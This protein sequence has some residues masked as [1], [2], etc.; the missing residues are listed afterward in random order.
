MLYNYKGTH[1]TKC[2]CQCDCGTKDVIRTAYQ[3]KHA[4]DSSCGCGRK[5]YI[6]KICGKE[7]DG[8]KFGR[9]TVIETMWNETPVRVKCSCE[10]GNI[11]IYLK[12]DVMSG[13]TKSCGCLQSE[14]TS[15]AN[16]VNQASKVSD[17]GIEIL[18]PSHQ[19]KKGQWIWNCKCGYCGSV[20]QELPAR[21]L[22]NHVKSC[23]CAKHSSREAFIK[24]YLLQLN[25]DFM[26]EYKFDDLRTESGYPMRFDF[27]IFHNG[28][29]NCLLEHD[30]QQHFHPV[31]VFGGQDAFIK[32]QNHDMIKTKYCEDNN[33]KLIRIPYTKTENEIRELLDNI[34]NP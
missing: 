17:Y 26:S 19:N 23:G 32:T 13:H 2:R 6:R 30:G 31:S 16:F 34:I 3:L 4:T 20:F 29:L 18:T 8:K 22:N 15:E 9:L 25:A 21:V 24:N 27:A 11:G 5:E 33:I 12:T 7:I 1:R 28:A 14:R 10:C